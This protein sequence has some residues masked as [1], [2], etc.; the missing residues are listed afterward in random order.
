MSSLRDILAEVN[1][2]QYYETFVK[3]C[4]DTWEDLSTITEDELEALGIP[5]GHRRR[6]QREIARRSG[7][8]E[9]MAL[10]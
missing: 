1:L 6:L 2:E 9:Y 7:W 4:F 10:P 3:A 8:P 5:R